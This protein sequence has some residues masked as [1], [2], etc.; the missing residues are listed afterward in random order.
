MRN[1]LGASLLCLGTAAVAQAQPAPPAPY[2]AE[3][4]AQGA[5]VDPAAGYASEF[6]VSREVARAN[7]KLQDEAITFASQLEASNPAGFVD[8]VIKHQPTFKVTI[9]YN[10]D[11]DRAALTRSAPVELRRYLV[12]NPLN[13]SRSE[14]MDG[15]KA[16][17]R[18]V[19]ALSRPFALEFDFDTD[20]YILQIPQDAEEAAYANA[21]PAELRGSVDIR[22]GPMAANVAALY[23]G[24]WFTAAGYC[25]AGWPIRD[26]SGREGLLTAGH[27]GPPNQM[28]FSWNGGPTLAPPSAISNTDNGW[29]TLDYA[30]YPLGTNTTSR[31]VYV[32]NNTTYNGYTNNV[33]GYVSA[34]YEITFPKQ[35]VNGQYLCKSGGTTGLSCG[36]VIDKNWSGDGKLNLVK[37]SKS[38]QPYIAEGGDSGGPVFSW[39]ADNSMVHPIGLTI[40]TA[41]YADGTPC[42]NTSTTAANNTTCYMIFLPLT[43]IRGYAPFTVNTVGGFVAP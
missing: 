5:A 26:S 20:R 38:A 18:A 35:P 13:R 14:L 11:V 6:K 23:A 33:P 8:L 19:S 34:Y 7:L 15:R 32:Q 21:L 39:S 30:M 12:F 41:R 36:I 29:Q 10:K 27:C 2:S 42:R 22:R 17:H 16:L 25:T 1:L 24:W 9:Y 40:S 43:T 37:V 4:Q 28:Y 31:V 3:L